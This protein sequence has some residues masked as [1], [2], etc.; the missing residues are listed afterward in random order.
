MCKSSDNG[1]RNG[2]G[3][4][5]KAGKGAGFTL[6][7][8]LVVIAII[9]ILAAMLLPALAKAKTK[10][11][12]IGC[13]ANLK[14]FQLGW[15]MYA[16]DNQDNLVPVTG[17]QALVTDPNDPNAQPGGSKS[18]WVLGTMD[19]LT[20]GTNTALLQ[21]GLIF[22]YINNLAVYKCPG[23]VV[24]VKPALQGLPTV[25]SY[26]MNCWMNPGQNP[27]ESWNT[28]MHYTGPPRAQVV[29]R[30]LG[31]I[32][33]PSDRYVLLDENPY[34]INDGFFVCDL[35]DIHYWTDVPASYHNGAGGL[36]FADGHAEIHRWRDS[37]VLDYQTVS[38]ASGSN[39]TRSDPNAGDLSWL[40]Q[41]ATNLQ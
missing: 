9:A 1:F 25:R 15:M 20:S 5:S 10:A 35:A 40:Q 3:R 4:A 22:S 41:R 12:G 13:M 14:Q 29:Y 27:D 26:S 19:T 34:S 32:H 2:R 36:S 6:I 17:A 18:S 31:S 21:A 16:N 28:T 8:L 11:Q 37:S 7:E 23:D 38:T 24:S 39:K 33:S 30:K